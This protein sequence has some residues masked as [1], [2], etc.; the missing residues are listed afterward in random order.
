MTTLRAWNSSEYF[1]ISCH[2]SAVQ[3]ILYLLPFL[4]RSAR[5]TVC[6]ILSDHPG[7]L[8]HLRERNKRGKPRKRMRHNT[9]GPLVWPGRDCSPPAARPWRIP[10]TWLLPCHRMLPCTW[11]GETE[12][13][14]FPET[15]P[16]PPFPSTNTTSTVV[17]FMGSP[18]RS[19]YPCRHWA[20]QFF[21]RPGHPL[22]RATCSCRVSATY[23]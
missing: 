17:I 10:R 14:V 23:R 3:V 16:A 1:P 2:S 5:K 20:E 6:L 15:Q 19:T 22:F 13:E 21:L 18:S 9:A 4:P 7:H 8:Y 12:I 11:R